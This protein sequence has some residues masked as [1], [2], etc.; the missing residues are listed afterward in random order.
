MYLLLYMTSM[1][2]LQD[3]RARRDEDLRCRLHHNHQ[4][5]GGK[6]DN[7]HDNRNQDNRDP[8]TKVKFTIHAFYGAYDAESYL[9]WEMT[10]GQKLNSHLVPEVH[11]VR[12][13]T[14]EFKDF[15][16]VWWKELS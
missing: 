10:V 2:N 6:N 12:Q 13:A 14:S 15:A 11:K 7:N 9:D 5:M 1:A 8:F 3:E 16:I 4:G